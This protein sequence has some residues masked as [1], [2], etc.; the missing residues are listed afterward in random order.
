MVS[1]LHSVLETDSFHYP[2]P[3]LC[4]FGPV[5]LPSGEM[6]DGVVKVAQNRPASFLGQ[7][8]F[9]APGGFMPIGVTWSGDANWKK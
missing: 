3:P 1:L 9:E 5:K 6:T 4:R 7:A 8:A 2:P